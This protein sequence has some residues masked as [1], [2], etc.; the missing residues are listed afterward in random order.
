M[1][2]NCPVCGF[3]GMPFPATDNNICSCC[4]TEFGYHDR[5]TSHDE[6]RR[7]WIS[8]GAPWFSRAMSP[9]PNW[10]WVSQL[11]KSGLHA[12][13]LDDGAKSSYTEKRNT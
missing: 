9:P 1:S 3:D 2:Y 10:D 7:I 12:V 11:Y 5:R 13:P 8:K 4:G 6:L